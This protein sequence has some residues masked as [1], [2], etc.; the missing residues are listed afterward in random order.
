MTEKQA[1]GDQ[2]HL[3]EDQ[4]QFQVFNE[5]SSS[6]SS[7]SSSNLTQ[8]SSQFGSPQSYS[9]QTSDIQAQ[10]APPSYSSFDWTVFLLSDP[11]LCTEFQHQD[12]KG[13]LSSL[14]EIQLSKNA[15]GKGN[16]HENNGAASEGFFEDVACEASKGLEGTSSSSGNSFVDGILNK[17][18][19]MKAAFPELLDES[20]YY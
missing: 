14:S 3:R 10:I 2:V 18:S 13:V 4:F 1:Q 12:L 7:S 17:D 20:F 15:L 19:E 6:C 5:P 8:L 11:F 9:C 16:A